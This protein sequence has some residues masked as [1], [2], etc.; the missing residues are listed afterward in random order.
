MVEYLIG[1]FMV[2]AKLMS[3]AQFERILQ[4]QDSVRVKLGLLAVSEGLLTVKQADEIN[5]LQTIKDKRFGDIAVEKGYLNDEQIGMLLRKQGN[6]YLT[7]IQTIVDEGIVGLDEV[8]NVVKGFQLENG[9]T[10]EQMQVIKNADPIEIIEMFIPDVSEDY[11]KLALLAVKTVIRNIDRHAYVGQGRVLNSFEA[12]S[13]VSQ[14]IDGVPGV[15]TG[16]SDGDGG[17]CRAASIFGRYEFTEL[18]EDVQDACGEV[19]NC[20]NGLYVSDVSMEEGI[21]L[22]LMPPELHESTTIDS[23][24]LFILPIY[25]ENKQI[26]FWVM[27]EEWR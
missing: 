9:F 11:R 24:E 13:P 26:N 8:D 6:E 21:E 4:I 15:T 25:I 7:F 5:F 27:P 14:R 20:I 3:E 17:M 18:D 23:D 22:E 2:N 16:F 12:I 10:D 1:N 19:V